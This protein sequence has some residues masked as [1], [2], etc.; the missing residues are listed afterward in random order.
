MGA[1]CFW[2]DGG[3]AKY[4]AEDIAMIAG[5]LSER[6]REELTKGTDRPLEDVW[7]LLD[8]A[9]QL[10]VAASRAGTGHLI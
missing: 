10:V 9:K 6:L 1:P 8:F 7:T 2:P 5:Y 4:S 3:L